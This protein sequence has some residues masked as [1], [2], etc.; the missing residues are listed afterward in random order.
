MTQFLSGLS[1]EKKI[2]YG[3]GVIWIA[4]AVITIQAVINLSMVR[5]NVTEVIE[6]KQPI[7]L[8][9]LEMRESLERTR[10]SLSIALL[11]K[12]PELLT[13]YEQKLQAFELRVSE[14]NASSQNTSSSNLSENFTN[15]SDSLKILHAELE[16]IENL[17]SKFSHNYPAFEYSNEKLLP[18]AVRLQQILTEIVNSELEEVG[19]ERENILAL[20][21]D[22][23]KTWLN[24]MNALRGYMAF[25]TDEMSEMTENYLD[26]TEQSLIELR[27]YSQSH[28]DVDLTLVEEDSVERAIEIYQEYREVYMVMKSIHSGEKW[29][30]DTWLMKNQIQPVFETM[31]QDLQVIADQ[32]LLEVKQQSE[33]VVDSSFWNII[34]LLL[35]SGIGQLFAMRVS[36][37]ITKEVVEPIAT[38]SQAMANIAEGQGDLTSRLPVKSQDEIGKMAEHFNQFIGRIHGMLT[39]I[40]QTIVKLEGASCHLNDITQ[41]MSN[42]AQQ[43]LQSSSVLTSSMS[44][45]AGQS[46]EVEAHS[47]NTSRATHQATDRVKES[48]EQVVDAVN[49]IQRLSENMQQMT[50]SVMELREDSQMI[51]SVISVIR[52][53]AEQTNLLSLNAAIEAAR[54]GEH[55]RGFA[56]VADEVRALANRTQESTGEIQQI[57]DKISRTTKKT[58][59]VVEQ[60]REVTQTSAQIIHESKT[61]I[62]PVTILMEDINKMSEKVLAVAH[63]QTLLSQQINDNIQQIHGV[64]ETAASGVEKTDAAASDLQKLAQELDGLVRQFKI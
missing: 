33:A 4:L 25:R 6:E 62:G 35:F 58:V 38:V 55:G 10:N 56:V 12:Q 44:Q 64:A 2:R 26:Q 57:I 21:I 60:G 43:Q 23:Q 52:E 27:N 39:Q 16:E 3:F 30:M 19:V 51:G 5:S 49:E 14:L 54:A 63:S 15:L 18:L 13:A 42:G 36:G 37:R 61:K 9:V 46:K 53:I 40:Q 8:Q 34:L 50:Q 1:I 7:V 31:E 29:R 11:L 28:P 24:V 45:M 32:L 22:L 59:A 41:T 48:S 20:T 47:Q 17:Q